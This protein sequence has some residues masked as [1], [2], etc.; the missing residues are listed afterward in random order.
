MIIFNLQIYDSEGASELKL[1]DVI[2][3]VGFL[4]LDPLLAHT[5]SAVSSD[6]ENLAEN[7]PPSIVPRLHAIALEKLVHINDIPNNIGMWFWC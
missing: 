6:A 7:P 2:D 5:S 3:V 4:S 1:N